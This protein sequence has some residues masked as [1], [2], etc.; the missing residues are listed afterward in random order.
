[1][2]PFVSL[3]LVVVVGLVAGSIIGFILGAG[4]YFGS[5]PGA[6]VAVAYFAWAA[7]AFWK[8]AWDGRSTCVKSY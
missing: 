7:T 1:M 4:V 5:I 2:K 8:I 3:V 6:V